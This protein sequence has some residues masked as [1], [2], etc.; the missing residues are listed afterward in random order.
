M[1]TFGFRTRIVPVFRS[2]FTHLHCCNDAR[3]LLR[4][5][6]GERVRS[7][8]KY[9]QNQISLGP[10]QKTVVASI[11]VK[12][13]EHAIKWQYSEFDHHRE[14]R[15]K[16]MTTLRWWLGSLLSAG[17]QYKDEQHGAYTSRPSPFSLLLIGRHRTTTL[18]VVVLSLGFGITVLLK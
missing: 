12:G 13:E 14:S 5:G 1:L 11:K 16:A 6:R 15:D 4:W 9:L 10:R 18:T 3:T 7:A 2:M 8:N 17:N